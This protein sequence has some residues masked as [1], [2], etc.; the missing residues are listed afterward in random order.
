[1]NHRFICEKIKVQKDEDAI[2]PTSF[3]WRDKEYRI[4][5]IERKWQD[6]GYALG[7]PP[8]KQSWRARHHRNYY[9]VK[10]ESGE[11]FEIYFD[12]G[13]KRPVRRRFGGQEGVW[14]LAEAID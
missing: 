8:K 13:T 5:E 2:N 4:I 7:R 10:T 1:M 3:R 14:I 9:R 6:F 12:R 11:R